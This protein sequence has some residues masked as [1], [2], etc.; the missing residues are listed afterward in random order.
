MSHRLDIKV[1]YSCNNH[2]RFCV[3]G[4][5]RSRLKDR[6]TAEIMEILQKRRP[7]N[8][9]V[10]FTGG[11]ATI[12]NDFFTLISYAKQLQYAMIQVQSNGRM[13]AYEEFCRRAIDA[14]V[15][16]FALALHGSKASIHDGLTN[17]PGS[18]DQVVRGMRN[19]KKL[20]RKVVTNTVINSG[21]YKDLPQTARLLVSLGVSHFQ[22]AFMHMSEV[23]KKDSALARQVVPRKSAVSRYVKQGLQIGIDNDTGV[24]VEAMPF[25][26]MQGYEKYISEPYLT[27]TSVEDE[28][29]IENFEKARK[30]IGKI[31]GPRCFM[32]VY[33]HICEGP[34]RGY[35]ELYGWSE[36]KPVKKLP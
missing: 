34:W 5:K 30:E 18:Y 15:N 2:C 4:N 28:T 6:T 3:Q 26:L 27:P 32:C 8:D 19:L 29:F 10:I 36:F 25:C 12:R 22:F 21:N 13:F 9:G 33:C 16:S 11:E 14:G 35:P 7:D 31:K 17:A 24:S 23:L 1:G 20:K